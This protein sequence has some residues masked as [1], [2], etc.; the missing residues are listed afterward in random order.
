MP[1]LSHETKSQREVRAS[2]ACVS[3]KK[4]E[5]SKLLV[6]VRIDPNAL[7]GL[8]GRA[9][10][11][12]GETHWQ[13]HHGPFEFLIEYSAVRRNVTARRQRIFAHQVPNPVILGNQ[14][15]LAAQ[16]FDHRQ[17]R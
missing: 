12:N 6:V 1:V 7:D 2:L 14:Q 10:E 15:R 4:L 11:R 13:R 5:D 8:F 9:V 3:T 16:K 17:M